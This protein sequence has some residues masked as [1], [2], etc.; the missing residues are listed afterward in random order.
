MKQEQEFKYCP[1]CGSA[2]FIQKSKKEYLCESCK[3]NFF[4][5]SAAAVAAIIKDKEGRIMLTKRA[6]NPWKGKL[7]L[8]G[9]FVDP[10]ESAETALKR[11][12]KEELGVEIVSYKYICSFPN[13]YPYS[14]INVKTTDLGFLVEI[15]GIEKIHCEDDVAGVVWKKPNEIDVDEIPSI[16]I[17]NFVLKCR[18]LFNE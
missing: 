15:E 13:V 18:E 12:L 11:E 8:P 9:G 6:Y 4:T 16:S 5:N 3:F 17:K 14:G 10:D 7:D 2:N 1:R